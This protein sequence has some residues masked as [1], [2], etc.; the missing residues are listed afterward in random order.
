MADTTS[1]YCSQATQGIRTVQ[2]SKLHFH[3]VVVIPHTYP[4][5]GATHTHI[6]RYKMV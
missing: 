3:D 4:V 5:G 2:V 1:P 6:H